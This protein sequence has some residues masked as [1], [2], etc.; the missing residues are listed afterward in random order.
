MQGRKINQPHLPGYPSPDSPHQAPAGG[1]SPHPGAVATAVGHLP[2]A[3]GQAD[4]DP[5]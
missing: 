4:Q 2:A 3:E 5:W 1:S